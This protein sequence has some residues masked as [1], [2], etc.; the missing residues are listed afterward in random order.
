VSAQ[1]RSNIERIND[2]LKRLRG[3]RW[4]NRGGHRHQRRAQ[5]GRASAS[6]FQDDRREIRIGR[7]LFRGISSQDAAVEL[8]GQ[9]KTLACSLMKI[10][11]ICADE[12]RSVGGLGEIELPALQPGSSIM[13]GRSTR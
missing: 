1:I 9:L 2:A 4:R 3:C 13:P 6:S 12:F 11:M 10:S 8:S 7:Q 5:L